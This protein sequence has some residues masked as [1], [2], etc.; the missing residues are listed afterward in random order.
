MASDHFYRLSIPGYF[1]NES[2]YKELSQGLLWV[3]GLLG[4]PEDM[5]QYPFPQGVTVVETR[6]P[7]VS[8]Y[9][10]DAA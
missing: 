3:S 6:F 1:G 8:E 9:R 4:A 10:E 2:I 7:K 5:G